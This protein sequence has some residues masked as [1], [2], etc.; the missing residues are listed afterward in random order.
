MLTV[1]EL[2]DDTTFDAVVRDGSGTIAVQF[3]A[4]WCGAC[5]VLAPA[6]EQVARELEGRVRFHAVDA[7]VNPHTV[8]RFA[9]RGLPTVLV[10]RDGQLADRIV[11]ALS[12]AALRGR[13]AGPAVAG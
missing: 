5:K 8:T 4:E 13:L 1:F 12:A 10:F 7:D 9:V 2:L 11:G 6:I 3:T